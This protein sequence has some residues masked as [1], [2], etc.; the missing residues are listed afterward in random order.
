MSKTLI[1]VTLRVD[2]I[3]QSVIVTCIL[4]KLVLINSPDI[5]DSFTLFITA[6]KYTVLNIIIELS[7]LNLNIFVCIFGNDLLASIKICEI[8]IYVI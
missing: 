5:P 4:G 2:V 6:K 3:F 1:R 7:L 8:Y